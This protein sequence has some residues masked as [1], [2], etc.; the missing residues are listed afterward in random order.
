MTPIRYDLSSL[1]TG[2]SFDDIKHVLIKNIK[3]QI[4]S[5]DVQQFCIGKTF[6]TPR[7]QSGFNTTDP[8]TWS[9]QGLK[10]RWYNKYC[11]EGYDEMVVVAAISAET[12]PDHRQSNGWKEQYT[13]S[14]E[15]ELINHFMW[16]ENEQRLANATTDPGG[17]CTQDKEAYVLYV[18]VKCL[19]VSIVRTATNLAIAEVQA[20]Q[21]LATRDGRKYTVSE[22]LKQMLTQQTVSDLQP[23]VVSSS[24]LCT[25]FI[26]NSLY[27]LLQLA[28]LLCTTNES[29]ADCQLEETFIK[30]TTAQMSA[31]KT[32]HEAQLQG[33]QYYQECCLAHAEAQRVVSEGFRPQMTSTDNYTSLIQELNNLLFSLAEYIS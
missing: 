6:I 32:I 20:V 29:A 12:L 8:T 33:S 4:G 19:T 2:L 30:F 26:D 5:S 18:A 21:A 17:K 16:S 13:L 24:I 3:S 1:P 28:A 7:Y 31:V 10:S 15:Q 14:L 23:S 9:E 11:K 25:S 27:S 22:E